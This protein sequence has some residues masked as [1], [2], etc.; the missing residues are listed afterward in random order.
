MKMS[1]RENIHRTASH[2]SLC[3]GSPPP[4][5]KIHFQELHVYSICSL[6][7][8]QDIWSRI[9]SGFVIPISYQLQ[10]LVYY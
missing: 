10:L 5:K 3:V 8:K 7:T 2:S 4:N 1:T 6:L 9:S